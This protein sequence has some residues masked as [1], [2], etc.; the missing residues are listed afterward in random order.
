[1]NSESA[2][3]VGAFS[4]DRW[5]RGVL[6]AVRVLGFGIAILIA[7]LVVGGALAVLSFVSGN[8]EPSGLVGF[9]LDSLTFIYRLPACWLTAPFTPAKNAIELALEIVFWGAAAEM[10]FRALVR[11]RTSALKHKPLEQLD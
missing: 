4:P 6:V 2:K 5:R 11:N 1:M 3:V 10:A 8:K 9:A 7:V